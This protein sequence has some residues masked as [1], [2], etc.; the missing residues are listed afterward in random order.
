MSFGNPDKGLCPNCKHILE[1]IEF[2]ENDRV[3]CSDKCPSFVPHEP[4]AMR[5]DKVRCAKCE[6]VYEA[7]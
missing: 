5:I 7:E 4:C 1:L 3:E 2:C 6:V